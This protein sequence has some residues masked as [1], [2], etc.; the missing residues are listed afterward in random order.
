MTIERTISIAAAVF[1]AVAAIASVKVWLGQRPQNKPLT[2]HADYSDTAHIDSPV[3]ASGGSMTFRSQSMW[4]CS[5]PTSASPNLP[6]FCTTASTIGAFTA[7]RLYRP[8]PNS[9]TNFFSAPT[10]SS[11][12]AI[13]ETITL[14][15]RKDSGD[16]GATAPTTTSTTTPY[17]KLTSSGSS[18]TIQVYN[19]NNSRSGLVM[20]NA[21]ETSNSPPATPTTYAV[22]YFN[23][24]CPIHVMPP[25]STILACEHPGWVNWVDTQN[26]LCVDGLCLIGLDN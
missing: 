3:T 12:S 14:Y 20:S 6:T 22:Q 10:S 7:L 23:P 24:D 4:T 5:V 11:S 18:V 25:P 19:V 13:P 1:A 21:V 16:P 2:P 17:I 8:D 9:S 26:Y 15:M